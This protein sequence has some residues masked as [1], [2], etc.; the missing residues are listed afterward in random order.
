MENKE[1]NPPKETETIVKDINNSELINF[2]IKTISPLR[3]I[4][5]KCLDCCG[6]QFLDVKTCPVLV[7][8]LWKFRLG[9]HPFTKKNRLNPFL[10]PNNFKGLE[11]KPSSEVVD[12]VGS[13]K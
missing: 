6:E 11:N 12:I 10:E 8:S 2:A 9:L 4:R 13:I 5:K 3:A 1:K 7:C